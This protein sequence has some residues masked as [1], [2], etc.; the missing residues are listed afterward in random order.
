MLRPGQLT[1]NELEVALLER[2]LAENPDVH[3][4]IPKMHVLSR[5]YTGVGSFTNFISKSNLMAGARRVLPINVVVLIPGIERGLGA[6][7]F[8]Q[9]GQPDMLEIV[10]YDERW[11]GVY[12]GFRLQSIEEHNRSV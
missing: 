6:V 2:L 12:D 5:E 10:T 11:D 7:M 8:F 9:H 1:P 4:D 3:L